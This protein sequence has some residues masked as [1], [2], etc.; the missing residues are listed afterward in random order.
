M[1]K[2]DTLFA[3]LRQTE[4]YIEDRGF[5]RAVMAQ[6][7]TRQSLPVWEKNVIL[8][9]ATI[10]GSGIAAWQFPVDYVASVFSVQSFNLL[11]L[12]ATAASVVYAFSGG[13]IL[14][15]RRELG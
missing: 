6:A 3:Q 7:P 10:L 5:A 13:L 4:P 15:T 14:A 2:F 12:V 9:L 11:I 1:D 8:M